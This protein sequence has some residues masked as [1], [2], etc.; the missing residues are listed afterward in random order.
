VPQCHLPTYSGYGCATLFWITR[1]R[2][3]IPFLLI[4]LV[5]SFLHNPLPILYDISAWMDDPLRTL[6]TNGSNISCSLDFDVW[7][8]RIHH[9][10]QLYWHASEQSQFVTICCILANH[11]LWLLII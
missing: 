2:C 8:F 3:V 7:Q 9:T 11:N 1:N 4:W 6:Y 5:P 10:P